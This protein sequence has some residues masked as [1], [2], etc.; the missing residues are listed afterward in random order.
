MTIVR[1]RRSPCWSLPAKWKTYHYLI[2]RFLSW[3]VQQTPAFVRHLGQYSDSAYS[4]LL[5]AISRQAASLSLILEFIGPS[6]VSMIGFSWM[7]AAFAIDFVWLGFVSRMLVETDSF[8][9]MRTSYSSFWNWKGHRNYPMIPSQNLS[10]SLC[11]S[12]TWSWSREHSWYL[13]SSQQFT[14][15]LET[16]NLW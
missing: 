3:Q 9:L 5:I 12:K 1:G 6:G 2:F 10:C 15:R 14:C 4:R 13:C 11:C 7:G 16:L 8:L